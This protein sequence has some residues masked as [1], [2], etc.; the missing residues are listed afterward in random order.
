MLGYGPIYAVDTTGGENAVVQLFEKYPDGRIILVG[1]FE[2][3]TE[4]WG[5]VCDD[6]HKFTNAEIDSLQFSDALAA[7]DIMCGGTDT[8]LFELWEKH[9]IN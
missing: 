5:F 9:E 1:T 3:L 8:N 4:M 6:D 2:D 7:I